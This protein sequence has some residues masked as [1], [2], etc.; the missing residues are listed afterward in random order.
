MSRTRSGKIQWDEMWD[1]ESENKEE[2]EST[3]RANNQQTMSS[4]RGGKKRRDKMLDNESEE[5]EERASTGRANN[6]QTMPILG[7]EKN[8]LT[9]C[10][11]MSMRTRRKGQIIQ[12]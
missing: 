7:E 3:G 5:E 10:R 6:P 12:V 9:R 2:R 1:D 11:T 8:A 4:T